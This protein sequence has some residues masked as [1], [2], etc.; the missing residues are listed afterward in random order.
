[1]IPVLD[2]GARLA[3][4]AREP[5]K[6][7]LIV[8][9]R[10]AEGRVGLVIQEIARVTHLTTARIKPAPPGLP[11]APYVLGI[12]EGEDHPVF[13]LSLEYLIN[14]SGLPDGPA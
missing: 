6:E 7:D 14:V 4:S 5:G 9:C 13:L 3:R 1:V 2:V 8:V 10:R 11:Q 12:V